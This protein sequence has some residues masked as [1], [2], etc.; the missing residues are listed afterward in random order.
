MKIPLK[1]IIFSLND[2]S[3]FKPVVFAATN[4]LENGKS[5]VAVRDTTLST[6]NNSDELLTGLKG[7]IERESPD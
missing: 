6:I 5:T 3:V 4:V 7:T 2:L 1:D